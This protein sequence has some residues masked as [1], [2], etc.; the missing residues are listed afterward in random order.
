MPELTRAGE[1][2]RS[3][4]FSA[5]LLRGLANLAI[6]AASVAFA[7]AFGEF[8]I[9]LAAPQQLILKRPDLWQPIDS[10]GWDHL[11]NVNTR[12][13]TGERTVRLFTDKDGY[14]VGASGRVDAPTRVL[15][16]GDSFTEA[17]QVEYEQ[18]V[19]GLL[20]ADLGKMLGRP[21]A[22]R[23]AGVGGWDPAQYLI[24][25]RHSIPRERP[26]LV[27]VQLFLGNDIVPRR[28]DR[29]PPRPPAEVHHFRM[30]RALNHDEIV[31][32]VLYPVNDV[33]EVRSHLF[34]LT[35]SLFQA[36][37]MR[38]GLSAAYFPSELLRRE[39]T[40]PRWKVVADICGDIEKLG[41]QYGAHTLFVLLPDRLQLD[42]AVLGEYLR[43]MRIP[44][45]SVDVTQPN[46]LVGDSL[47]A[48]H[49][50]V[51][52]VTPALRATHARGVRL[53]GSV[54]PHFS[55]AGHRV[56]AAVIEPIAVGLLEASGP[57]GAQN[58]VRGGPRRKAP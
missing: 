50:D 26:A 13:N 8:A 14:R 5:R 33:L 23:N 38:I 16:L 10:L 24:Q 2:T 49:L 44:P 3:S 40:A 19:A 48:R 21:V 15:L 25:A 9:R 47:R 28:V 30:P 11:A 45:D 36:Q 29:Y 6:A 7:C 57:I 32:A 1:Q 41:A 20:Q 18:S 39:A 34:V 31:D 4:A 22:V 42:S 55:P 51:V 37:L 58:D 43:S 52:D 54:D 17:L 56:A 12:I 27:I 35:K 53:Y 46:R